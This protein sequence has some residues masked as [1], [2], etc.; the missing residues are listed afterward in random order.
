M[1][2]FIFGERN[3]IHIIN[4]EISIQYLQ[5]A[6]DFI[7]Q[8]AS[9]G[10]TVL[11]VGTKKQAQES[12]ETQ[13]NACGMPFVNQRWL[14][15][16]L[17]NFETIRRSVRKVETIDKMEADGDFQFMTKKEVLTLKKEREKLIRN[18]SGV[19]DMKKLP[20]AVFV[21][22]TTCEKIAIR[23]ARKLGIPVVAIAD[24]NSDPADADWAIPGNDD[25]IKSIALI[26]ELVAK[27]I[28]E[29]KAEI[30]PIKE[31]SEEGEAKSS[32]EKTEDAKEP[33][34]AGVNGKAEAATE[35]EK[36]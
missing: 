4:L 29:A 8:V 36:K 12:V 17:T 18:L 1:K 13:A 34:T 9:E 26:A 7:R 10:K 32:A 27:E 25:A 3:G 22:D 24:S 33:A 31:T 6:L 14:G 35:P 5:K 19:R 21:I 16:M 20:G 28:A 30:K 2:P 23:E 15:G 11:F